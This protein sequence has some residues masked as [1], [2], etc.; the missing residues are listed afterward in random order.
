MQILRQFALF[1]ALI[2]LSGCGSKGI[3]IPYNG[4]SVPDYGKMNNTAQ[5][6]KAT[7]RP[8]QINGKWYYPEL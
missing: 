3:N 5:V 2:V 8:Y 1:F 6:Q 4:G 7:M